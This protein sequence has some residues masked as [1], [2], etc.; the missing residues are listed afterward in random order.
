MWRK[1]VIKILNNT[2]LII[3]ALAIIFVVNG[4]FE[5]AIINKKIIDFKDRAEYVG[6]DPYLEN[7]YYYKVT[8][9]YDYEDV[10]RKTFD[11]ENRTNIGS[12]T[13]IL[14]TNR[15]PMR[16]EPVLDPIVGYLSN[17]FFIGHASINATDDGSR[18]FEVVGNA[19]KPERNVVIEGSNDWSNYLKDPVSPIII[20]LRIK[21]TTEEQRNKIVEYA[22]EQVGKGYNYTFIFN[23]HNT[24]YCTD[25]VSRA[26][27]HAGI[28]INY[29]FFSTTGN[30]MIISKKVYIFF[31]KE[32]VYEDEEIKFNIYYLE[33]DL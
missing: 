9:E 33:D 21:G 10:S 1:R 3:I 32:A 12:K 30:D 22:Y 18:M 7:V 19:S 4:Y 20:G 2:F 31:L 11:I 17:N 26:A 15:N 25:L 14:I 8:K 23:R 6:V 13:D 5:K 28:N 16:G 29:D 27:K 24:Y